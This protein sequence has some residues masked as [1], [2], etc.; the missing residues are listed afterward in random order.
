ML[1]IPLLPDHLDPIFQRSGGVVRYDCERHS[2]TR[3]QLHFPLDA[4]FDQSRQDRRHLRVWHRLVCRSVTPGAFKRKRMDKSRDLAA[5]RP[6]ARYLP[7]R[8][9]T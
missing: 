3:R 9:I 7:R 4:C 6:S 5:R 2:D 8:R 1:T